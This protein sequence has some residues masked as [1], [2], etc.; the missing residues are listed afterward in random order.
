[1][2]RFAVRGVYIAAT[3]FVAVTIVIRVLGVDQ[4]PLW[5]DETFTAAAIQ[6]SAHLPSMLHNWIMHDVHPPLYNVLMFFLGRIFGESNIALR[7]PS[8]IFSI[9]ALGAV[10]FG[11]RKITSTQSAMVGLVLLS[12]ATAAISYSQEARSYSLLMLLAVL[13]SVSVV[14]VVVTDYKEGRSQL[15]V[16]AVL[17]AYTHY[18]GALIAFALLMW[19]SVRQ[20]NGWKRI[21]VPLAVV[22]T[23]FIPWVVFHAP[24]LLSKTGG[25]FWIPR[26]NFRDYLAKALAHTWGGPFSLIFLAALPF[27]ALLLTNRRFFGSRLGRASV[28]MGVVVVGLAILVALV[29]VKTPLVVSRYFLAFLPTALIVSALWISAFRPMVVSLLFAVAV[30]G[31]LLVGSKVLRE[32][33]GVNTLAWEG[34]SAYVMEEGVR[35]VVFYL[36]DPLS[37][38]LTPRQLEDLGRFFFERSGYDARVQT[39]ATKHVADGEPEVEPLASDVSSPFAVVKVTADLPGYRANQ[40][41]LPGLKE[42]YPNHT[43]QVLGPEVCIFW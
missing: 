33:S 24:F 32:P 42:Q 11:L 14:R 31:G 22:S 2:Q 12:G 34:A 43:C 37:R 8:I 36:D 16:Y 5:L 18:F 39:V 41:W 19:L 15:T 28:E 38:H 20:R 27:G 3:T 1:M 26:G 40:S 35:R 25:N 13:L 17:I 30:S 23:A 21:L 9:A 6:S 29:S 10:F 7:A 4:R